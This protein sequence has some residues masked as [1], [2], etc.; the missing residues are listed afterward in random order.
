VGEYVATIDRSIS[1]S[2]DHV[3]RVVCGNVY[4][5]GNE[6]RSTTLRHMQYIETAYI[7]Q[8]WH[9]NA[10]WWLAENELFDLKGAALQYETAMK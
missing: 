7:V 10:T 6:P 3:T 8:Y 1:I 5:A 9:A 2:L 4:Q